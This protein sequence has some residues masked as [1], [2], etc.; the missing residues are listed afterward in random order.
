MFDLLNRDLVFEISNYLFHTDLRN[1]FFAF[2]NLNLSQEVYNS[3]QERYHFALAYINES[4]INYFGSTFDFVVHDLYL[5]DLG[6]INCLSEENN[7]INLIFDPRILTYILD[8]YGSTRRFDVYQGTL[9][10]KTKHKYRFVNKEQLRNSCLKYYQQN[11]NGWFIS[12]AFWVGLEFCD[13]FSYMFSA[14]KRKS[15]IKDYLIQVR[16]RDLIFLLIQ[17]LFKK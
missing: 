9:N 11:K 16:I 13:Y 14:N 3:C 2:P 6:I 1:L 10:F 17:Y 15:S 7:I 5:A 4:Y 8:Q 12:P